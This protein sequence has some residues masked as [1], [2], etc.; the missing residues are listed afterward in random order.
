MKRSLIVLMFITLGL[1]QTNI[2]KVGTVGAL[3]L[4]LPTGAPA[5]AM[6]NAYSGMVQGASAAFWNPALL[7]FENSLQTF[8]GYTA[9][10]MGLHHQ[11]AAITFRKGQYGIGFSQILLTT[12]PLTVTTTR[13]PNGTGESFR[14]MDLALGVSLSR[15]FAPLGC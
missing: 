3:F 12:K 13:E 6:G 14:Y 9:W 7:G 8:T 4:N 1:S 2:D 5:Q 15:A 10:L 11:T